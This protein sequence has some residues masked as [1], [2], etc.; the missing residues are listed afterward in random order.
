MKEIELSIIA[1]SASE[2]HKGQYAL[3]FEEH[4]GFRRLPVI[5]GATEAQAIAIA[6]EQMQPSRPLTHDLFHEVIR[7]MKARLDKVLIYDIRSEVFYAHLLF[8][9]TQGPLQIDARPSDAIALAVRFHA[10]IFATEK[11]MK[12][13]AVVLDSPGKA[14][15]KKRGKLEDYSMEELERI[16]AK[17]LAKE[18]YKS[19]AKIRDAMK[20]K[21]ERGE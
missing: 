6:L 11:V 15:T 4:G 20:R 10:P 3:I 8:S 21:K 5:I 14:F 2:S 18:D 13:A 17:L 1:L 9:T 7:Q 12:T 16:L 19:A